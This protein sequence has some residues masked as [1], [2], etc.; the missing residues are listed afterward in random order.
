ML[1]FAPGLL[2]NSQH[3]V[4]GTP[5]SLVQTKIFLQPKSLAKCSF[6]QGNDAD[7]GLVVSEI[8]GL[9]KGKK[10]QSGPLMTITIVFRFVSRTVKNEAE[11]VRFGR[12]MA[13]PASPCQSG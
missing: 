5:L 13:V 7:C 9:A 6:K 2:S 11:R 1:P 10:Q 8:G 4:D 12:K 3:K